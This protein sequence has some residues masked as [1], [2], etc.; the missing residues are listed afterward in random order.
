MKHLY[1]TLAALILLLPVAL[2]AQIISTNTNWYFGTY[3]GVSFA[4]ATPVALTDSG[5][6]PP[7][8][9][10]RDGMPFVE[11][12]ATI[13][14]SNGQLLFYTDGGRIWNK[15]HKIMS[16]SASPYLTGHSS[17]AQ[18]AVIVPDPGNGDQYYVFTVGSSFAYSKVD[19]T[20]NASLGDVSSVKNV[21]LLN[22][23]GNPFT[24]TT[25]EEA[26]TVCKNH[27]QS[28][29]WVLIPTSNK[30]YAYEVN[31]TG[32]VATPV[33]SNLNMPVNAEGSI[34][35]IKVSP[36]NDRVAVGY[37]NGSGAT[38]DPAALKVYGFNAATGELD[39]IAYSL[40][41]LNLGV[42]GIEFSSSGNVLYG[43]QGFY[44]VG[45]VVINLSTGAYRVESINPSYSFSSLARGPNGVIY[46]TGGSFLH[47]VTDSDNYATAAIAYDQIDLNPT[48]SPPGSPLRG[49]GYGLPQLVQN[50]H[51]CNNLVLDAAETNTTYLYKRAKI[52]TQKNT[53]ASTSYTVSSGKNITFKAEMIEL[54]KDTHIASGSLFL[55]KVESCATN[56]L[57]NLRPGNGTA[58]N[59]TVDF[60][61]TYCILKV[62][63]NPAS[64]FAEIRLTGNT[65][66]KVSISSIDGK[67]IFEKAMDAES[68][69]K[70]DI[71]SYTKGIYIVTV[72][73]ADGKVLSEKIIKQ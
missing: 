61:Q 69:F 57:P 52:T 38:T 14:N 50:L 12:C 53:G 5:F 7:G 56:P 72:E 34:G 6:I 70:A 48:S 33:V 41:I 2:S 68:S 28:K 4:S 45:L 23:F 64:D 36:N 32:V 20:L 13:S 29:Y 24:V 35:F 42:Y 11:G 18:T 19:M 44:D 46:L 65:I 63:P 59:M 30:L 10:V 71:S 54:L 49:A 51:P 40:T 37:E 58:F 8:E 25:T 31:S 27:D 9:T 17:S 21:A 62:Y 15:N 3:G 73:T 26:I 55:A 43:G 67:L 60:K 66:S 22:Q 1:F 47:E 39:T 16:N